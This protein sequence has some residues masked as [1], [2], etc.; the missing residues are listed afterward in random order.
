MAAAMIAAL[1]DPPRLHRRRPL[2][3]ARPD[4]RRGQRIS[5]MAFLEIDRT[6]EALRPGRDPARASTSS[7]KRAASWCWSARPAAAS[8][9]CSTRSPGWRR[10]P[11]GEIRDR[12]PQRINDLHPSKRDIAMVFQSYALYP[13]MTVAQNIAFGLEMR[14]VPKARARKGHRQGRQDAADRPPAPPQA[15]PALRRP[16]PAR[17]HGP[18]A[19][20]RPA[21]LPV[22]RA[23]VQPRRQAARRHAHRDQAP[24]PGHSA[25]PSST[26]P[27][28][29]SRR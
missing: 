12:R 17:R 5:R 10:S 18:R 29:R 7:S 16:A 15:E 1:P 20:A 14:G 4:G 6:E 23:A 24:A 27:T 21:G 2:F 11:S 13:N 8:R 3:R 26:S 22:R 25:R 19:G 9:R 28:T